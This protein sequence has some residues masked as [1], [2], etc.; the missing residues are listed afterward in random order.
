MFSEPKSF[1]YEA[2]NTLLLSEK[3]LIPL[4]HILHFPESP[5]NA[6]LGCLDNGSCCQTAIY[7]DCQNV[8]LI[9]LCQIE[10]KPPLG[11]DKA[12]STEKR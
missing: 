11:Q 9:S 4:F 3:L 2:N 6:C 7:L 10:G 1:K 8:I 12:F 5:N